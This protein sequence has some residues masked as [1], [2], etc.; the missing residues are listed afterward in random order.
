[1]SVEYHKPLYLNTL[2][3]LWLVWKLQKENLTTGFYEREK[4]GVMVAAIMVLVQ[5]C[6]I[7]PMK[8]RVSL[9]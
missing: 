7:A 1:M 8:L 6:F 4:G 5:P 9:F 3:E 2:P